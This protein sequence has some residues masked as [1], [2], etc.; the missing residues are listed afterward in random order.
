MSIF[1]PNKAQERKPHPP[2]QHG[3]RLR[4]KLS[5]YSIGLNEKQKLRYLYGLTEKQFRRTFDRAKSK[6]GVTSEIFL[7][8]LEKRLDA[9]LYSLGFA[10]TRPQARQFVTHGHVKVNG[11]KV[12]IPSY[13]VSAGDVIEVKE[14]T[15][16]RQLAT[17]ALDD[18]RIRSVPLWLTR[19]DD[20]LTATVNREPTADDI[21]TGINVQQI[22]EFYSR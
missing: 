11:H 15:S 13:T 9:V 18:T 20:A 12:D 8:M 4:R 19:N 10:K 2:G 1:P 7:Q 14:N 21:E 5:D 6:R 16:S 22:V 17:R 3:P